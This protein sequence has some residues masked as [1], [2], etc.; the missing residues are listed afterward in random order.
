[1]KNKT[2]NGV[3]ELLILILFIIIFILSIIYQQTLKSLITKEIFIYGVIALFSISFLLEFIPQYIT[4]HLLLIEAKIL[5]FPI[6]LTFSLIILGSI[7]GSLTGF[8]I[9]K[10]YGIKIIKKVYKDGDY[11]KLQMKIKKYGKWFMALAAITPLPYIPIFFGSFG[12]TK[13]DFLN[14]GV[15]IRTIGLILFALFVSFF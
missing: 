4:P 5:E 2:K 1:M 12:V 7:L 9:G 3:I 13:K 11:E 15:L 14:Y 10:K 6:L 8:E